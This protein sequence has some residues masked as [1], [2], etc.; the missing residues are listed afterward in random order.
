MTVHWRSA[1]ISARRLPE[2]ETDVSGDADIE[3][4]RMVRNADHPSGGTRFADRNF[5][6]RCEAGWMNMKE[7]SIYFSVQ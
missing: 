2:A 7:S 1:E 6:E 3:T 4:A 5:R